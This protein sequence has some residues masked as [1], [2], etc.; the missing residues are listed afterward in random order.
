VV[1]IVGEGD[2]VATGQIPFTPRAKKV[3]ELGLREALSLGDNHV[4]SEHL[5][6]GFVREGEGAGMQVLQAFDISPEAVRSETLRKRSEPLSE[7][8]ERGFR[9]KRGR[10]ALE[11]A[12]VYVTAAKELAIADQEFDQASQIADIER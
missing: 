7:E 9:E 6:L 4:G 11:A 10:R 5:L 12:L 3:L 1:R 8:H 2:E